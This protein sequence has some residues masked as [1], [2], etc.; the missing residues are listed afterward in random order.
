MLRV[1]SVSKSFFGNKVLDGVD[2]DV[3]AGEVHALVGEN[4]AGKSTLINIV[5]GILRRDSGV[6]TLEGQEVDFAHPLE[7]MAAGITVVHQELSVAPNATVAENIFLRRE[8][9]NRF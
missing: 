4:G 5:A 6:I 7:A 9:I 8:K 1:E 2:F 3:R